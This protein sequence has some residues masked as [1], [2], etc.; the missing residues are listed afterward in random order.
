[1]PP[2]PR[3]Q[4]SEEETRAVFEKT[5]GRCN[6]RLCAKRLVYANRQPG[7]VGAWH[8]DHKTPVSR[9]GTHHGRNLHPLCWDCNNRKADMTWPEF[10]QAERIRSGAPTRG[11]PEEDSLEVLVAGIIAMAGAALIAAFGLWLLDRL[12][13]QLL[14][15]EQRDGQP[16]L[17]QAPFQLGPLPQPAPPLDV[18][19]PPVPEGPAFL[20]L[21]PPFLGRYPLPPRD[22]EPIR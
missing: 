16:R 13:D 17:V 9:G 4:F 12:I 6:N 21:P 18:P 1:M 3:I 8:I 10:L 11:T 22:W 2:T 15:P 7:E 20:P 14:R 19:F 5:A